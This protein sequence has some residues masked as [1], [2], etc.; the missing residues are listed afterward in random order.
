MLLLYS[1]PV[2][3]PWLEFHHLGDVV[4]QDELIR[5][6]QCNFQLLG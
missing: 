6:L 1:L 3:E 5:L 2:L 4:N